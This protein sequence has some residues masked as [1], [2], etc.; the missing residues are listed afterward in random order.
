M[1]RRS[2]L[3]VA[4]LP[5]LLL[6]TA[7][8]LAEAQATRVIPDQMAGMYETFHYAPAVQAGD[9]LYLAGV[10][11]APRSDG[12]EGLCEA[13]EQAF[14]TAA[15]VLAEAG[16]TFDDVIEMT[17]FHT[18]LEA[19]KAPFQEV[20]DR[21]L[22]EPWP[23]WTAI[24]IDQLWMPTAVVEIRFVAWREG[25]GEAPEGGLAPGT[26]ATAWAPQGPGCP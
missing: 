25:A 14:T 11:G 8:G 9:F 4:A 1:K 12:V 19:Q 3:P 5:A 15:L 21:F 24:D 18:D 13:A 7:P 23:A 20:R 22:A 17:S 2:A 6:V 16:Y 26:Q 10:V